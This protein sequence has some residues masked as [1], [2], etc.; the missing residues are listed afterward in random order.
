MSIPDYQSC[1]LPLLKNLA[2][3]QSY[4]LKDAVEALS[5]Q[6]ELTPDECSQLLP[7]QRQGIFENR[8]AWAKSY[9]KQ[10]GLLEYPERGFMRITEEGKR[11]IASGIDRVDTKYLKQ[12]PSFQAFQIRAKSAKDS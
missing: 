10:A 6:F 7:S 2:N 11:V 5:E 12:Y 4:Q 8:V 1:M 3:G 9:L